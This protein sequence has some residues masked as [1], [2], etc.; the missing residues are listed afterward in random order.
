M[1]SHF[2][3][4]LDFRNPVNRFLLI[5]FILLLSTGKLFAGNLTLAWN[6]S[7]SGNVGGYKIFYGLSSGNY[8]GNVDAGKS[9][10]FQVTGLT[11]GAKYFFA[12]KAYNST[13]TIQ[14]A[15]SNEIS[16]TVPSTATLTS[17]FSANKTSGGA[18][19]VVSFTPVTTGTV[20]GW[21]WNFGDTAIP[22]STSQ[23]PTVT[24]SK[25]GTY[26]VRLTITGTGGSATLTKA[27]LITVTSTPVANFSATPKTGNAPLTVGFS[28]SSSGNISTRLWNFGD[29]TTS[30]A[31]NPNH[32]YTAAGIYNV[33]LKVTGPNGS[34]TKTSSGFINV[35][36]STTTVPPTQGLV[37]AYSFEEN[38]GN[39]IADASGKGNHGILKEATHVLSG[40]HHGKMLKF[41]G[42]NDWISVKDSPSLD[43]SSGYTLEAWVRPLSAGP[44]NIITKEQV[45]GSVYSL[46][47]SQN[48]NV[49][50]AALNDGTAYRVVS[51]PAVVPINKWTHL[52]STYNGAYQRLYVN[53][54]QV[55]IRAQTGSI[56]KSNGVL[57]IGG[58]SIWGQYF[59]GYIDDIRIYNRALNNT[60][61]AKDF[62]TATNYTSPA[63]V[64][65]GNKNL[66]IA[67]DY[68]PQG[69]AEAFKTVLLKNAMMTDIRI[70]LDASSSGT[71]LILG[72]YNDNLGHPG[73]LLAQGKSTK[74]S[75]GHWNRVPIP[76]VNLVAAKPYWIAILGSKGQIKFRDRLGAGSSPL[77]SSASTTLTTLPT[78]WV[79]G[80]VF[81]KDGPI[82][83][84]GVGYTGP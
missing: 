77:E 17:N 78:I 61:I 7:T 43:L 32:I 39:I 65:A 54:V 19:L 41:D 25:P 5:V 33:S 28:D 76:T 49:P 48:A 53:G 24:Y 2:S 82:S 47:S 68:N 75:S 45:G 26:S 62:T 81:P 21:S 73:K 52:V 18:P 74:L 69:I 10:S 71:E 55:A 46:Y 38:G 50:I 14:S 20:T 59:H 70:Y 63:R 12:V 79:T 6:A 29:G 22:V 16:A 15:F 66:E 42:V 30:A 56:K 23:N 83:S 84:F 60:E 13:K 35:T 37:A 4:R 3:Y 40:R 31:L 67:I 1:N 72:I 51:G 8:T 36:T 44:G 34:N 57:R 64:V 58:N 9:T 11:N 80:K 27:G